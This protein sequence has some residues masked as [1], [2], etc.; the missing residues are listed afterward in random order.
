MGNAY[1]KK[2]WFVDKNPRTQDYSISGN[3]ALI[4]GKNMLDFIKSFFN[5]VRIT[6]PYLLDIIIVS[7]PRQIRKIE[8]SGDVDRLHTYDTA[9][10]PWWVKIYF[11]ATKF[12]DDQ[13]DLWF[14]PFEPTSNP[15]YQSR[16]TY[17]EEKVAIGY[18]Q[19]D[20]RRIAQLLNT[21]ADDQTLA[22]EMVQIVNRRFFESEIPLTI[23]K[24]A[25][26]TLQNFSEAILPWNYLRAVQSQQK[27]MNYCQRTLPQGVHILDAGHNIGEVV[28]TTA[29]AL[30]TL[31]DNLEKP[32]AEI[33]TSHPLTPQVPR[34]ATRSSNFDGLLSY[35]T[36]AGQT[37]VIFKIGEAAAETHDI[38]FT[39]GTGREERAC[40][41][42]EFFM[43]FMNDLQQELKGQ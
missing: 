24:S 31:K 1:P 7:D 37:V 41:F 9:S 11:R 12:H 27:I 4:S 42:Q 38:S 39:F 32:V 35:P 20:V 19:A 17:L 8:T 21:N 34:I 5:P 33:F 23:T 25:K 13:R 16:R 6:I 36:S 26:D 3:R 22:H 30:R 43:N 29:G 10:L 28:Q 40:V 18:S 14:C 2:Q 15:T